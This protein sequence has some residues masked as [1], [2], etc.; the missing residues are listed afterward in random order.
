[1]LFATLNPRFVLIFISGSFFGLSISV[2]FRRFICLGLFRHQLFCWVFP[3]V[4]CGRMIFEPPTAILATLHPY[5]WAPRRIE[6]LRWPYWRLVCPIVGCVRRN[7]Y[8][9]GHNGLR[10][11]T[12]AT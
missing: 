1:M 6:G 3:I 8:F 5:I 4:G 11:P 7:S 9:G 10:I 2:S 12:L